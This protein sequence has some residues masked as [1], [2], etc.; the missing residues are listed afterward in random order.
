[1]KFDFFTKSTGNSFVKIINCGLSFL[2]ILITQPASA[3]EYTATYFETDSAQKVYIEKIANAG[4]NKTLLIDAYYNFGEYLDEIGAYDSSVVQFEK[5]LDYALNIND[6]EKI[7]SA[8]NYLASMY[9]ALGDF[10][11]SINTY[12]TALKSAENREDFHNTAKISMNM[13]GT[14]SFMGNYK[15][16]INYALKAINIKESNNDRVRIC[17]HYMTLANIFRENNNI[18]KWKEYVLKAY[19]LKDI[20]ECASF[21]DIA[22]IYN[23]LGGL[24]KMEENFDQALAYYDTLMVLSWEAEFNQG[25][26]TALTNSAQIYYSQG[27]VLKALE[28]STKAE[29]YFGGD[30]YE[31]IFNNNWKAELYKELGNF[32]KAL[33]LVT[34]NIQRSDINFYYTEKTKCLQ[35]LYELNF[36]L[37]NYQQAYAWND[38]LRTIEQNYHDEDIRRVIQE[39]ETKYETEKKQKQIELLTSENTVKNQRIKTFIALLIALF[40]LLMLLASYYL[41]YRQKMIFAGEDLKMKLLR[42]QMN[43]HFIFN[44]LGSI[45]SFMMSND[46]GKASGYLSSFASLIRATLEYS[47]AESI[48]LHDELTMLKDYI[49]LEQMRLSG[50]FD[51]NINIQ[52]IEEPEFIHI[53]P[54]MVQPFIENA[55][56]HGFREID[57]KGDLNISVSESEYYVVFEIEDNGSGLKEEPGKEI[58]HQSKALDIFEQR[59]KLIEQKYKRSFSFEI[60]NLRDKNP[61]TSGVC[62]KISIPILNNCSN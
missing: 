3:D 35:L 49:N 47:S 54:M 24:A 56:K 1:M 33:A 21:P 62:I 59:R 12:K 10:T 32:N 29:P 43:P 27:Q 9:C 18:P 38:S 55:I 46:P 61:D 13:A 45:Q 22:K 25:I 23:S 19:Q 52:N 30:T 26:S 2:L 60:I 42:S 53:P 36:K 50:K 44:V 6:D 51:Y 28:L 39:T 20:E 37:S 8:A 40:F 14:Y 34:E 11:K 31:I 4:D 16:A 15:E 7:S 48:S 5:A 57:Y 17:Y 58:G 41:R